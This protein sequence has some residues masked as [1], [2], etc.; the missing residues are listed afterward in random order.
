MLGSALGAAVLPTLADDLPLDE[1]FVLIGVICLAA[2]V[3]SGV[4]LR[5]TPEELARRAAPRASGGPGRMTVVRDRRILG[6]SLAGALVQLPSVALLS[7]APLLLVQESGESAAAA[8]ISRP[9]FMGPGCI[10]I[11][12]SGSTAR[13]RASNPNLRLYSMGLGKNE[14]EPPDIRSRCTRSIM[15]ASGCHCSSV[16]SRW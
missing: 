5:S 4:F 2:A 14:H 13:R 3:A 16:S 1:A 7:F 8:E 15:T 6:V 9:R 10:T 12:W 11:A